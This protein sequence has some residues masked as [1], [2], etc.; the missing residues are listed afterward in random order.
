MLFAYLENR[1]SNQ[2]HTRKV[3]A[4]IPLL[5]TTLQAELLGTKQSACSVRARAP[6]GH[7]TN[8]ISNHKITQNTCWCM[9][10]YSTQFW[11]CKVYLIFSYMTTCDA[12][13]IPLAVGAL[14]VKQTVCLSPPAPTHQTLRA[15]RGAALG[16]HPQ[17]SYH[18]C[19]LR[20]NV[21][22]DLTRFKNSFGL[23]SMLSPNHSLLSFIYFW[24]GAH[25]CLGKM[26]RG[27]GPHS[28]SK[29]HRHTYSSLDMFLCL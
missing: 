22:C 1:S 20:K 27:L 19:C 18:F 13:K 2:F 5:L 6:N 23:I 8:Q 12:G 16:L 24:L 11:L 25:M 3:Q 14:P 28:Y 21:N 15:G 26:C 29:P 9:P 4:A 7:H 17:W 10:I